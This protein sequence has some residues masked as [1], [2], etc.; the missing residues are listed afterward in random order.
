MKQ[1]P[2]LPLDAALDLTR[3]GDIW[4]FRGSSAADRLIRVTTNSP[5]NHVGMSVVL[6]DLPPLMWHAELGRS[7]PD[8]W[9]G[10]HHRGVQL[11]DLRDAVTT[12]VHRYGQRAWLR[13]LDGDVT[14][15]MEDAVLKTVARLDGT[16]FPSTA[17]LA[18][19]WLRGRRPLGRRSL[20]PERSH[21]R[22]ETAYCAEVLARTYTAMSLLPDDRPPQWY[23]PGRFWS[24]DDL[25]LRGG[26]RLGDEV[27]VDAPAAQV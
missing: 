14:A 26:F 1:P 6:E 25:P 9:S 23:D 7:L 24:G 16:P 12:W 5:V 18:V 4:L 2:S 27:A 10:D 11:H 17:A 15:Q 8:V 3:T 19:G 20:G 21:A 22:I 13:Q